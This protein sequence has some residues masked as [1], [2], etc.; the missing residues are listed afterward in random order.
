[1]QPLGL[2]LQFLSFFFSSFIWDESIYSGEIVNCEF[3]TALPPFNHK[4]Y[5]LCNQ[6][7]DFQIIWILLVSGCLSGFIILCAIIVVFVKL[8]IIF[9][10][11]TFKLVGPPLGLINNRR[12]FNSFYIN[13]CTNSI[14][15][16]SD[17]INR[18]TRGTGGPSSDTWGWSLLLQWAGRRRSPANSSSW[19]SNNR[20]TGHPPQPRL[21]H[22][23]AQSSSASQV[24]RN[25][26]RPEPERR[27]CC[28]GTKMSSR[29]GSSWRTAPPQRRTRFPGSR[30]ELFA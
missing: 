6:L 9:F 20:L 27:S 19:S 12:S 8:C 1:M 11:I 22:H 15:F 24:S 26:R 5:S 30:W 14:T 16:F 10:V 28:R 25:R 17:G 2:Q 23:S 7:V 29:N 13:R 18:L 3:I 4:F 21:R